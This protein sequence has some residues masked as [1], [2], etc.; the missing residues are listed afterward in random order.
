MKQSILAIIII[1]FICN[2]SNAQKLGNMYLPPLES[3]APNWVKMMYNQNINWLELQHEYEI[4]YSQNKFEKNLYTQYYKRW[5]H[6]NEKYMQDD[7]SILDKRS[8]NK[9]ENKKNRAANSEWKVVGP[10]E[11]FIDASTDINQPAWPYQVNIYAFDIAPSNANVMYAAPETGGLFKTINKGLNWFSVSD[12]SNFGAVTAVAID[13]VNSNIVYIGTDDEILKT[14]NGGLTWNSILTVAGLSTNDLAIMP[15]TPNTILHGGASGLR[16]SNNGGTSWTT[17]ATASATIYDI[18]INSVNNS[19]VYILKRNTAT[20]QT[21]FWRSTDM[22]TTFSNMNTGWI[23]GT[24]NGGRIAIT[25]ADTNRIYA[26]LLMATSTAAPAIMRSNNGGSDWTIAVQSIVTGLTGDASAPIGMS[27]GQGYYD[28][29]IVVNNANAD[30]VIVGTTTMYKST[31]GASSFTRIGG[32]GGNFRLHPDVQEMKMQG[33]DAWIST[34]GGMVYSTDFFTSLNNYTTRVNGIYGSDFWGFGQGWNEDL[35]CGGRYHNGNTAM[36]QT[37]PAGKSLRL[38][39]GEAGTGFA[40]LGRERHVAHSDIGGDVIPSNFT[41]TDNSS[42][43]M[44]KYPNEDAY[45]FDAGEMEFQHDCFNNIYITKDSSL[46]K[47]VDGGLS[48]TEVYHFTSRAKKFEISRSTPNTMYLATTSNLYKTIDGGASWT[49]ITRPT[50]VSMTKLAIAIS[51]ADANTFWITSRSN[52][53]NNKVHKST[54]GGAT[55]TNLTNA[56]INPHRFY[57]I[58]HHGGSDGG[59][60][61]VA[62]NNGKVFYTNNT[63]G[64]AWVDFSSKLP[65]GFAPVSAKPF[66]KNSKL[67]VAGNRG[68]WEIDFYEEA[69]PIAQ[70]TVDKLESY[71]IRDTFRFDCFSA[72]NHN[73]ATWNWSFPGATY[74]SSTAVRNPKV[75][76]P[77]IGNYTTTLTVTNAINQQSTKTINVTIIGN[78]CG[79]DTLTGGA[80]ELK[81]QNNYA[82]T[83]AVNIPNIN[84]FTMMCWVKGSGT[85]VDY[86]GILSMAASSGNVHLNVRSVGVDSAEVGYHHP[87]GQWWYSSGLYLVPNVWTHLAL[88]VEPTQISI[89][90]NGVRAIHSGLTVLPANLGPTFEVGSMITREGDRC[91]LGK[92][93]EVAVYNYA[94]S[95]NEIRD[96]MHLTKQNPNYAQ[97]QNVGLKAYYQFNEQNGFKIFDK[98]GTNDMGMQGVQRVL[99][100]APIG[101]GI[102]YRING[103]NAAGNNN[104]IGTGVQINF[105]NGMNPNGDIIVSRINVQPDQEANNFPIQKGYYVVNNFGTNKIF[106]TLNN[107]DFEKLPNVVPSIANNYLLFTRGSN[108]DG[109]TWGAVQDEADNFT[110]NGT[111]A[112]IGFSTNN[113]IST[114]GQFSINSKIAVAPLNV[115]DV[116]LT[117]L[118]C[119]VYPNPSNNICYVNIDNSSALQT[120]SIQVIDMHG[121][122]VLNSMVPIKI[123]INKSMLPIA[124]L[125]SGTYAV[126]VQLGNKQIVNQLVKN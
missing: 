73:G 85:Q 21:E 100:T 16:I 123:G 103:I 50:G 64:N 75:L 61:I 39:G 8:S 97:Q 90:K 14:I 87:N 9:I 109:A 86:A 2:N 74:V 13:P 80:L 3:T 78:E 107:I 119:T 44:G 32:Y 104:F 33:N 10:L 41:A 117:S 48:Y 70:P 55:F 31:D 51:F 124:S 96:L 49:I 108:S 106:A 93:D 99:S 71:C 94:L 118:N 60:Y 112:T 98:I 40:L 113:N 125:A 53:S 116:D 26:V 89:Y 63:L 29:S 67:R 30:D 27:N 121:K 54:D 24:D 81:L 25:T 122:V 45:G 72:L 4:F 56:T 57:T 1:F 15:N 43:T 114:F 82:G 37:Y 36:Y 42:F 38:G 105:A 65:Y 79:I 7:G 35:L 115:Q 19:S 18:E 110:T 28:L 11:T 111:N 6:A 92:I 66:Y 52:T 46:W 20:N 58:V 47:S 23:T 101:G 126:I 77:G 22:A 12:S 95:T 102:S 83:N 120:A 69:P 76:Y 59:V 88:V 17:V 91:F 68:I 62:E 5:M 34:D 84:A